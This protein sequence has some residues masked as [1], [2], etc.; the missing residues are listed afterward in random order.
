[1]WGIVLTDKLYRGHYHNIISCAEHPPAV[2]FRTE[3]TTSAIC[4][5]GE[6]RT[7]TRALQTR[8]T[9][10]PRYTKAAFNSDRP[11]SL[12]HNPSSGLASLPLENWGLSKLTE[13]PLLPTLWA[14]WSSL[15]N[16]QSLFK[17]EQ[18][19]CILVLLLDLSQ[20]L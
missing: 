14:A 19:R 12:P 4:R 2:F 5:G 11:T 7:A 15:Q 6:V 17:A 8:L 1:M 13:A 10:H 9:P 3:P 20:V 18:T 16:D